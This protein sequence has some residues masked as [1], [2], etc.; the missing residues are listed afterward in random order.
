MLTNGKWSPDFY[1]SRKA[2]EQPDIEQGPVGP[3]DLGRDLTTAAEQGELNPL[4]GRDRELVEL[5]QVLSG[6]GRQCGLIGDAGMGKTAIVEG[7]AQRSSAPGAD[8][9]KGM[10]IRTI[11][12]A[13]W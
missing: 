1:R 7:L 2:V 12:S 5:I 10:R 4:I 11:E 3:R 13:R 9:L 6:S 8:Q